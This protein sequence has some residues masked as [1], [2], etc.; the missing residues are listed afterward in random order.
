MVWISVGVM[1]VHYKN[2]IGFVFAAVCGMCDFDARF[3]FNATIRY[4]QL[5]NFTAARR[6]VKWY[7]CCDNL[8]FTD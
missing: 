1:V 5:L 2:G 8:K 7:S 6:N 3:F 4:P